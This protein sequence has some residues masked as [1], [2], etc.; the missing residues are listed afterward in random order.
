MK[1]NRK[2]GN[3]ET[4]T[5]VKV[6]QNQEAKIFKMA[7]DPEKTDNILKLINANTRKRYLGY[8]NDF[9]EFS[10]VNSETVP[11]KKHFLAFFEYKRDKGKYC[12]NTL[13]TCYSG[14]NTVFSRLYEGKSLKVF[15]KKSLLF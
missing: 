1:E 5:T 6:H 7:V 11:T 8:W 15:S 9:V 2:D 3:I 13:W 4:R 12:G 10:G 14:V